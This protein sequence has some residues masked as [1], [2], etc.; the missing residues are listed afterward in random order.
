MTPTDTLSDKQISLLSLKLS[1]AN[2]GKIA[3]QY[4]G[5]SFSELRALADLQE[6][7][8]SDSWLT[9]CRIIEAWRDKDPVEHHAE[10]SYIWFFS[11][12]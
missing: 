4:F 9:K 6:E 7:N 11:K 5:F 8:Q 1:E 2:L 3:I 10:V 12:N